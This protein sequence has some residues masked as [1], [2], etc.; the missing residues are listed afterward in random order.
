MLGIALNRLILQSH[1]LGAQLLESAESLRIMSGYLNQVLAKIS[2]KATSM[3]PSKIKD[4][5]M[6]PA[7]TMIAHLE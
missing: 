3:A 4:A 1:L 2:A 5:P 6:I 7:L